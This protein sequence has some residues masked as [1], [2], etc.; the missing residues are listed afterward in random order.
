MPPPV[1]ERH[2]RTDHC[3]PRGGHALESTDV[4]TADGQAHDQVIASGDRLGDRGAQL[5]EP[6]A[7]MSASPRAVLALQFRVSFS[8][9]CPDLGTGGRPRSLSH[10]PARGEA[11]RSSNDGAEQR[12]AGATRDGPTDRSLGRLI[13]RTGSDRSI[14]DIGADR[15]ADRGAGERAKRHPGRAPG[16]G[17]NPG[18]AGCT[19]RRASQRS[20]RS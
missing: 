7:T 1:R 20:R 18:A 9:R 19:R 8:V 13:L 16:D 11:G 2:R 10:C 12:P 5:R 6:G 17:P 4:T 15:A 3:A 14:M